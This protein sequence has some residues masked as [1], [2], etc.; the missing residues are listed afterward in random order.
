MKGKVY[1]LINTLYKGVMRFTKYF[2]RKKVDSQ[3]ALIINTLTGAAD[4]I[5]NTEMN[6]IENDIQAVDKRL[7]SRGYIVESAEEEENFS[8]LVN[9]YNQKQFNNNIL[10]IMLCLTYSCNMRCVYCF[11][12]HQLHE[13]EGIMSRDQIDYIFENAD[14]ILKKFGKSEYII[15]LFGGEPIQAKTFSLAKYVLERAAERKIYVNIITN[16]LE[17]KGF[18]KEIERYKKNVHVQITL[19]GMEEIH[20][21]QRPD[22]H[23]KATY[24]KIA[25]GIL[26]CLNYGIKVVL[27]TNVSI[28]SSQFISQFISSNLINRCVK[29]SNFSMEIAPVINHFGNNLQN[30]YNE[31]LILDNILKQEVSIEDLYK[32]NIYF[33]ADMFRLTGYLRSILDQRF[34][35]Y[36][37]SPVVNYCEATRLAVCAIGADGNIYLC[38]ETVGKEE[39]VAGKIDKSIVFNEEMLELLRNRNIKTIEKCRNCSIATLCGGG[40]PLAA[41]KKYGSVKYSCC[42]NAKE[43]VQD[44]LDTH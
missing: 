5:D 11:Q 20:N 15:T 7:I 22:S 16:G 1:V 34:R 35:N 10:N 6:K 17:I 14:I 36:K 41:Q 3:K 8:K 42:G 33:T 37:F 32:K 13:S 21:K 30:A 24:S 27:R 28:Y 29:Y 40:C 25:S 18:V 12:K 44:F 26:A 31:S 38:P 43:V 23:G 19:D 9:F 39:V 2:I 4:I